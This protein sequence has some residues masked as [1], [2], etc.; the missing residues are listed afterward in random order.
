MSKKTISLS[1][2]LLAGAATVFAASSVVANGRTG[3]VPACYVTYANLDLW[4]RSA[5]YGVSCPEGGK[6]YVDAGMVYSN[7]W[8]PLPNT[9]A[10]TIAPGQTLSIWTQDTTRTGRADQGVLNIVQEINGPGGVLVYLNKKADGPW[11]GSEARACKSTYA[12]IDLASRSVSLGVVC[13]DGGVVAVD[14]EMFYA[15]DSSAVLD[16]SG[17]YVVSPGET[18]TFWSQDEARLGRAEEGALYVTQELQGGGS[19]VIVDLAE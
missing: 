7:Q 15:D 6:I 19:K 4:S 13:P 14:A 3:G 2:A 8:V 18:I 17:N 1:A 5:S 12:D 11:S 16:A 9:G 10:F